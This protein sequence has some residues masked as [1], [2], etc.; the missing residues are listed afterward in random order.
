MSD[1]SVVELGA[2]PCSCKI[3][4]WYNVLVLFTLPP[5]VVVTDAL[6]PLPVCLGKLT[7]LSPPTASF[8]ILP[9]ALLIILYPS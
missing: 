4:S 3:L 5:L 8:V 1:L 7:S 6:P 2:E 9:K